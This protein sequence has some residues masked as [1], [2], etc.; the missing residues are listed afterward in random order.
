MSGVED[1]FDLKTVPQARETLLLALRKL[2]SKPLGTEDMDLLSAL[3]RVLA[4]DIVSPEDVPPYTRSTVDGYAVSA[5][6]TFG[7]S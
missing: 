2:P 4:S 6:D 1:F 5:R 7:A 3:G